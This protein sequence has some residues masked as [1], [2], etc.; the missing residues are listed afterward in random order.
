MEN[1]KRERELRET[2][3]LQR[4]RKMEQD[5]EFQDSYRRK[6]NFLNYTPET[7]YRENY[8]N[9]QNSEQNIERRRIH[10]QELY[11]DHYEY[12]QDQRKLRQQIISAEDVPKWEKFNAKYTESFDQGMYTM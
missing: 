5:E 2:L 6:E 7:L 12:D 10:P 8:K 3:L 9:W 11:D 1:V 4:R